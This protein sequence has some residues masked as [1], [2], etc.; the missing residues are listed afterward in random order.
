MLLSPGQTGEAQEPSKQQ[1]SFG[2]REAL[3]RKVLSFVFNDLING[4]TD[5]TDEAN[6]NKNHVWRE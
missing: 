6:K 5:I 4:Q 2:N 3:D 1:W